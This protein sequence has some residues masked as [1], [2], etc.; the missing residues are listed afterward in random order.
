MGVG[1]LVIVHRRGKR[2]QDGGDAAGGQLRQGAGA[3]TGDHEIRR[4]VDC[5]HLVTET[6]HDGMEPGVFVGVAHLVRM[7]LA[8]KMEDLDDGGL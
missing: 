4:G 7:G 3:G 8:G 5:I 1:G 6:E 2:D